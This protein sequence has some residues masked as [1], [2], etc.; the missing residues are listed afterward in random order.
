MPFLEKT[1]ALDP[2]V[3]PTY[4]M[5]PHGTVRLDSNQRQNQ[6]DRK[7]EAAFETAGKK[8]DPNRGIAL[9]SA[10]NDNKPFRLRSTPVLA[11]RKSSRCA[12]GN[13]DRI[14]YGLETAIKDALSM[15]YI[16]RRTDRGRQ[17]PSCR[18]T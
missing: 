13:I 9:V 7:R 14:S 1:G 10:G 5:Y 3:G 8:D 12:E 18:P 11:H 2:S 16:A 17:A 15:R 4:R 6:K